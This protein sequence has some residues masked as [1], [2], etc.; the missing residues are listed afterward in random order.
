MHMQAHI[1]VGVTVVDVDVDVDVGNAAV[2]NISQ[3]SLGRSSK[4]CRFKS[5]SNR[6][7]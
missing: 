1:D 3:L 6:H 7:S 4:V 5:C 2:H